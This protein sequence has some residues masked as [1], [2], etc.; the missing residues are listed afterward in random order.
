MQQCGDKSRS[1]INLI[2]SRRTSLSIIIL[3]SALGDRTARPGCLWAEEQPE[4]SSNHKVCE[5][6]NQE[7]EDDRSEYQWYN[8]VSEQQLPGEV[9]HDNLTPSWLPDKTRFQWAHPPTI[10]QFTHTDQLLRGWPTVEFRWHV[11]WSRTGSHWNSK[12]CEKWRSTGHRNDIR[13]QNIPQWSEGQYSHGTIKNRPRR[14]TTIPR[15]ELQCRSPWWAPDLQLSCPPWRTHDLSL[16]PTQWTL[17]VGSDRVTARDA[18]VT[19]EALVNEK[20][21]FYTTNTFS[22]DLPVILPSKAPVRLLL[23]RNSHVSF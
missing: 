15:I 2:G 22:N 14:E 16:R 4:Q 8:T 21:I 5:C 18:N 9:S 20:G 7:D 17:F 3:W 6:N 13:T 19:T 10:L 12:A 11:D 23:H 1:R